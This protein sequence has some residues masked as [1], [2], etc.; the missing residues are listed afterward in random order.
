MKIKLRVE[1]GSSVED[2]EL[3]QKF[4]AKQNLEG[5]E[6]LDMERAPHQPGEQGLGKFLGNLVLT[7][8]GGVDV[9]KVILTQLN[10]FAKKWD[11]TIRFGDTVIPTNKLSGD[12]I[13]RIA[14]EIAKKGKE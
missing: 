2:A 8:T 5:V 12:Q 6:Q 4:I 9:I 1:G 11:R 14:I 10:E 7:L 13:E 3:L